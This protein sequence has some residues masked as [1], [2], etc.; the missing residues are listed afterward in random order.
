MAAGD[1]SARAEVCGEYGRRDRHARSRE[2]QGESGGLLERALHCRCGHGTG[3][4]DV[5]DV[6]MPPTSVVHG[7][8]RDLRPISSVTNIRRARKLTGDKLP[9][10]EI[11]HDLR[12]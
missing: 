3:K 5:G 4:I 11:M 1:L 9:S 6:A 7:R 2:G 10:A 12:R 8:R